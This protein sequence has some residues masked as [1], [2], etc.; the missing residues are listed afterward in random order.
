MLE[1]QIDWPDLLRDY[2][3][4]RGLKQEAAALDL[5]ISQATLSRWENGVTAPTNAAC[6]RVL[7][8]LRRET[9]PSETMHFMHA[10]RRWLCMAA[11]MDSKGMVRMATDQSLTDLNIS[12]AQLKAFSFEDSVRGEGLELRE[13]NL[14]AGVFDGR[15][16]VT[17][18]AYELDFVR[19]LTGCGPFFIH[20]VGWP[21]L[22]ENGEVLMTYQYTRTTRSQAAEIRSRLGGLVQ[23]TP[24]YL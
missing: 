19:D 2:R 13:R 1:N 12:E 20:A 14:E 7:K 11:I 3:R 21:Y 18:F 17:E 8:S 9:C 6:N 23:H 10:F 15:I 22:D 16:A 4:R 5:G 24:I